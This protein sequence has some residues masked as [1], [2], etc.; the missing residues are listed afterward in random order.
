M[1]ELIT[2]KLQSFNDT[3]EVALAR[4]ECWYC[5][6]HELAI[7]PM[8][9]FSRRSGRLYFNIDTIPPVMD[10]VIEDFAYHFNWSLDQKNKHRQ[11][12]EQALYEAANFEYSKKTADS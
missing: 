6:H 4:A 11:E 8:D 10:S 5:I 12:I 9:F 7:N 2:N 3:I 1:D